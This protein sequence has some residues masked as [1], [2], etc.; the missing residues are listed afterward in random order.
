MNLETNQFCHLLYLPTN[1]HQRP[2]NNIALQSDTLE[3]FIGLTNV[4]SKTCDLIHSKRSYSAMLN[5][6]GTLIK[7]EN[8]TGWEI[9]HFRYYDYVA[10]VER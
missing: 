6:L 4:Y 10:F 2:E 3:I 9:T 8:E 7:Q 5:D 1:H